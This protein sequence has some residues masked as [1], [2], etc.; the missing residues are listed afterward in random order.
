MVKK[1]K[2]YDLVHDRYEGTF[3]SESSTGDYV[4][5]WDV[6]DLLETVKDIGYITSPHVR[7]GSE[8]D[9]EE[10]LQDIRLLLSDYYD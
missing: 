2:R 9:A 4:S 5:Y 7:E 8:D 3:I 10:L 6:I 1:L